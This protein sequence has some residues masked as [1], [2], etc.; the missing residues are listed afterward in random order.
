MYQ[1]T[2]KE[3]PSSERP[4]ERL[5]RLGPDALATAELLAIVLRTGVDGENVLHMAEGLLA[6]FGGLSGLARASLPELTATRGLGAAK[7]AQIMAAFA[8]GRRLAASAPEERPQVRSP[9]DAASLVMGE[10]GLLKQEQL[11]V[12]LLDTQ[13]RV[14]ALPTVYTGSVNTLVVRAGEVFREAV[15]RNC[16]ALILA[17]NHPSGDPTPSHEDTTLTTHLVRAGAL[18]DIEV[19]DHLVIGHQ[20]Y[21]SMRKQGLGF[22]DG[23]RI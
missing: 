13:N 8:L 19:L 2:I 7:A 6:R 5:I 23:G 20:R 16:A 1:L 11:R 22:A 14:V 21:V 17:H 15:I 3:M 4:R 9:D 18:L 10:M 12:I